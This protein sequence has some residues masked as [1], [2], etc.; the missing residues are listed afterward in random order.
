VGAAEPGPQSFKF[1]GVDLARSLQTS[2]DDLVERARHL[3]MHGQWR[4]PASGEAIAL[5]PHEL[6][7]ANEQLGGDLVEEARPAVGISPRFERGGGDELSTFDSKHQVFRGRDSAAAADRGP[8]AG[9]DKPGTGER[10]SV[11]AGVHFDEVSGVF[12]A[13]AEKSGRDIVPIG[14]FPGL[15]CRRL[16]KAT[17][18]RCGKSLYF[19]RSTASIA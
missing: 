17:N 4:N 7:L 19:G 5:D 1:A 9:V 10:E 12:V 18:T 6:V 15:V 11:H 16:P 3:A 14:Q 2:V 13:E 8:H